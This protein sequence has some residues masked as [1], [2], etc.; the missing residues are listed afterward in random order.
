MKKL[1]ISVALVALAGSASA[2]DVA[3]RVK[4]EDVAWTAHPLFKGVQ[5]AVLIGD[6][7]KAEV[8]VQRIKFPPNYRVAPHTHPYSEVVTVMSGS[9][10][11]GMGENFDPA[12]GEVVKAGSLNAIPAKQPHFVWTGNEEA[13]IQVQFTG[14]AG[15]NFIN[16]ADDPR[17]K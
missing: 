3:K 1:L 2:Q 8:V 15:I 9:F 16:L 7:T 12:K 6:P 17:K 13:I 5:I 10:G 14:P 11:F 4:A